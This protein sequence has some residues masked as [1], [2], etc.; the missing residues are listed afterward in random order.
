M[1]M[2]TSVEYSVGPELPSDL[3]FCSEDEMP[4]TAVVLAILVTTIFLN[5]CQVDTRKQDRIIEGAESDALD[6]LDMAAHANARID[7]LEAR[8]EALEAAR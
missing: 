8:V 2:V 1:A 4:R 5:G 7:E 3:V 6:A